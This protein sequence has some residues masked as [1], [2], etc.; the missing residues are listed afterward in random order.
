MTSSPART[1][2]ALGLFVSSA[3]VDT[4]TTSSPAVQRS[5]CRSA[6]CRVENT[7]LATWSA[8]LASP[9][10]KWRAAATGSGAAPTARAVS[11]IAAHHPWAW[12]LIAS[13]TST[14]VVRAWSR[15]RAA[16]SSRSIRRTSPRSTV[17]C[18]RS[19]GTKRVRGRSQRLSMSTRKPCGVAVRRWSMTRSDDGGRAWASSTTTSRGGP[20]R[21]A[22]RSSSVREAADVPRPV[23]VHPGRLGVLRRAGRRRGREHPAARPTPRVSC[24]RRQAPRAASPAPGW[25]GRACS[26]SRRR[27]TNVRGS[28]GRSGS[29]HSRPPEGGASM[30]VPVCVRL[31]SSAPPR[32][33]STSGPRL[34]CVPS[35]DQTGCTP[36]RSRNRR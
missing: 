17:M 25:P 14:E 22:A 12:S 3:A 20:A 10:A 28:R 31:I 23:R 30:L 19:S 29:G 5:R 7:S 26:A 32:G 8:I 34:R 6:G 27:G 21:S 16:A 1:S 33:E 4:A 18:P 9:R 11:T 2:P 24:R 13:S 36:V 35:T 15:M